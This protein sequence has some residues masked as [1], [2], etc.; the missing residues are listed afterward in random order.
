MQ[1]KPT[2]KDLLEAAMRLCQENEESLSNMGICH[3]CGNEQDGCEPDARNYECEAC[4]EKNVFGAE[5]TLM[6]LS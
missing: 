6:M 4:E 3:A 5:E 1:T 2:Q